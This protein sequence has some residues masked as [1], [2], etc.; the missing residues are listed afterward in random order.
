MTLLVHSLCCTLPVFFLITVLFICNFC[1]SIM[2]LF[3][4][5]RI[6]VYFKQAMD[7]MIT[8]ANVANKRLLVE[9]ETGGNVRYEQGRSSNIWYSTCHDLVLSRFCAWDYKVY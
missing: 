9:L 1:Q 6:E 2:V 3:I 8:L 5:I 4:S 7:M